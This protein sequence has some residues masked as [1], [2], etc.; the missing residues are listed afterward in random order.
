MRPNSL[1]QGTGFALPCKRCG[2]IVENVG[3]EAAAAVCS[4]CVQKA[5][6]FPSGSKSTYRPT[7]KPAGWHFMN[8]YVD[9]GGNVFHKGKEV[10][11][12]KGTLPPTKVKPKKKTKRRTREQILIDRQKTKKAELRK[13]LKRQKDF[14]NHRY[15]D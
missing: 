15:K 14:L 13:A 2:R 10:P 12:L 5:V 9:Q 3:D 7:G 1:N 6:G 8:E 4:S 11:E